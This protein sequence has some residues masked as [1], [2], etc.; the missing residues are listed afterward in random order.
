MKHK[1]QL[2][3]YKYK[4]KNN[5]S[6]HHKKRKSGNL[7]FVK[8]TYVNNYRTKKN[9]KNYLTKNM[10]LKMA[11]NSNRHSCVVLIMIIN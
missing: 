11:K 1:R 8:N 10:K 9:R 2:L 4:K 3:I 6:I 7:N 5:I